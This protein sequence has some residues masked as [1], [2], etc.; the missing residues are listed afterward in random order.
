MLALKYLSEVDRKGRIVLPKVPLKR[1]TKVEV[2]VLQTE[3]AA[4]SDL[5]RAAE[6]TLKFWDNPIDDEVWNDA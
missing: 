6:T 2:I 5:L 4:E 1:G 3:E